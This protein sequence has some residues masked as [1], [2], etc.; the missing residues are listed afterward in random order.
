[1]QLVASGLVMTELVAG[2]EEQWQL[3]NKA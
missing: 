1:V 3:R 2:I